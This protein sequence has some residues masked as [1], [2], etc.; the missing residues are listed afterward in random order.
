MRHV[1][2]IPV[3]LMALAVITIGC[4]KD[5]SPVNPGPNPDRR[6]TYTGVVADSSGGGAM[7]ATVGSSL[8]RA[9]EIIVVTGVFTP[10][11]GASVALT[12]TYNTSND[13]LYVAGGGFVFAGH[14]SGGQ[15]SGVC[16]GPN[17]PGIFSVAPSTATNPV[18]VYAG[19]FQ[20]TGGEHGPFN[21]LISGTV[22][23]GAAVELTSQTSI[24]LTGSLSGSSVTIYEAAYPT[25][26]AIATGAINGTSI[27]GTTYNRSSGQANGNW[28]G[29]LVQ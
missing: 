17:G 10:F 12:G 21:L 4:K 16:Y 24:R 29:E 22:I 6:G 26:T 18:K 28:S 7:T 2:T 19:T 20:L 11:G 13:S 5:E 25:G 14:F 15:I 27:G 3:F 9:T 1:R 23:S 8:A